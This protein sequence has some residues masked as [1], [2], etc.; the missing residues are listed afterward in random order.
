MTLMKGCASSFWRF[1]RRTVDDFLADQGQTMVHWPVP[2]E[3]IACV[4]DVSL[5]E[6]WQL[7]LR[8]RVEIVSLHRRKIQAN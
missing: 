7:I 8:L 5:Q 3:V 2:T 6:I 1:W 4:V